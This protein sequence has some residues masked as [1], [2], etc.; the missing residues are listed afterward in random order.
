MPGWQVGF[1]LFAP[2]G[3]ELTQIF[4]SRLASLSTIVGFPKRENA[5]NTKPAPGQIDP[6]NPPLSTINPYSTPLLKNYL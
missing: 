1:S 2:K 6:Q 3:N 4:C 5:V